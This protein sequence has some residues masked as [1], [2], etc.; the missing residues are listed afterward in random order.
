[1][2]MGTEPLKNKQTNKQKK[3]KKNKKQ[4]TTTTKKNMSVFSTELNYACGCQRSTSVPSSIDLHFILRQ[5]FF[6]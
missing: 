4:K 6:S 2:H 3:Q 1:V 5:G